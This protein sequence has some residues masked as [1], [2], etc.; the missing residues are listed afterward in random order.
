VA[1]GVVIKFAIGWDGRIAQTSV[2]RTSG[3]EMLD[4][5]AR[6][7]VAITPRLPPLP[8]E[9]PN[10]CVPDSG[11][12]YTTDTTPSCDTHLEVVDRDLR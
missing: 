6:T 12:L 3:Y 5:A 4:I 10:L 9:F 1:G 7:S 11:A 8:Q 2:E